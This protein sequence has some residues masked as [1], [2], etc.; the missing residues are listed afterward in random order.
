MLANVKSVID[1]VFNAIYNI[2]LTYKNSGGIF[3]YITLVVFFFYPL[4]T[5]V[6]RSLKKNQ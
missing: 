4:F 5:R 2:L 3:F 1:W 6:V